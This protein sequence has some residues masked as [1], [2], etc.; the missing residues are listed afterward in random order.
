MIGRKAKPVYTQAEDSPKGFDDFELRLGDLMRGERATMGKSLL[1]VQRELRIKAPYIA[2]IENADPEAFD[3]P[4]FIAGY[5]RS[6]AR[7][8]NLD[9]DHTFALF[10]KESGFTTAHGMSAEASSRKV[11]VALEKPKAVKDK[12]PFTSP[13]TPFIPAG[14]SVLSGIEPKAIGSGLV[15]L[16]LIGAIGYG[17]WAVLNEIQRVQVA[18]VENTPDVLADL[19]PLD[20]VTRSVEDPVPQVA[21]A[22]VFTPPA[23]A[24]DR[25]YR[26]QA[27]DVPV[28]VSRDAPISTL[29]P[30][31]MGTF[32]AHADTLRPAAPRLDIATPA[33]GSAEDRAVA[34]ALAGLDTGDQPQVPQV[35]ADPKPGVSI[36]AVR[37]A[38]V[39]VRGANG[40]VIFEKILDAG[41]AYDLPMTEEPPVLRA[42]MSGSLY[43]KVEG[44]LYGPAGAGSSTIRDVAL[45]VGAVKGAYTVADVT[46]DPVAERVFAELGDISDLPQE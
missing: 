45:S 14:D 12:D 23:D 1:D 9:P 11:E 7:Y 33:V 17:G 35:L 6:Y 15:L 4:G 20:G 40:T 13:N 19:D 25:L 22:G 5:V 16:A 34:L 30:A 8:L 26:P 38:W 31:E 2:A 39:R 37:P 42:G 36:V 27:L 24:L 46:A 18:P 43:F 32:T 41:E 21:S 10:C 44:Q 29:D 3:T 28:L